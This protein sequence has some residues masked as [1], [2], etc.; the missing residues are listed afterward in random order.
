VTSVRRLETGSLSE[1]DVRRWAELGASA[2]TPNP[3]YEPDFVL[4]ALEQ[5][6]E[7]QLDLLVATDGA[8]DWVGLIPVQRRRWRHLLGAALTGWTHPHCF[9]DSPLISPG[10]EES[11]ME[12][13]LDHMRQRAGLVAFDR[14]PAEG[15]MAAAV[16]SACE[17]LGV[18]P[19]V[20][21]SFERAG[22]ERR[23]DDDYVRA[24]LG[25][26]HYRELGRKGRK[27]GRE[28]GE[29]VAFVD[30]AGD[31]RAVDDLLALEAAGWKGDEGT[32]LASGPGA[33]FFRALCRRFSEAGRLQMLAM[34]AG[35]R[36]VAMSCFLISGEGLFCFKIAYDEA[37]AKFSPGT[38][39][40]AETASEF[41]RRQE[42]QWV[43]SC[44]RP[45]SE[46]ERLWPDRRRLV[47]MLVPG[48]G[49][50]GGA[51]SIEA[52]VAAALRTVLRSNG[53]VQRPSSPDQVAAYSGS[54]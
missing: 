19:I 33:E 27:L 8:G 1:H 48:A 35:D 15:P 18:K 53:Q 36:T 5:F 41:H 43:D 4:T 31:P 6:G 21:Q 52:R 39:L 30:R 49:P 17:R 47:T 46:T 44:S 42:L 16:G 12:A 20:W 11:V 34:Q 3:F 54:S 2:A 7:P 13:L 40:M 14:F 9:L 28:L 25:S 23:S 10:H 22:L 50:K 45:N 32:A 26:K 29:D 37:L 24:T 51:V 38:Q